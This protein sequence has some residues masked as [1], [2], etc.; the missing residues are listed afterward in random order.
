MI[1][2]ERERDV[3]VCLNVNVFRCCFMLFVLFCMCVGFC[4]FM[5]I[6][7]NVVFLLCDSVSI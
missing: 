6:C 4:V 7:L 2:G 3:S 1:S 5:C